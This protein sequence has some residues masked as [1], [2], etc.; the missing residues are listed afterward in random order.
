M[1]LRTFQVHYRFA[2]ADKTAPLAEW[3]ADSMDDRFGG[4]LG[5]TQTTRVSVHQTK[6]RLLAAALDAVETERGSE[7]SADEV[8]ATLVEHGLLS[9]LDRHRVVWTRLAAGPVPTFE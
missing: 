8:D 6:V 2:G 5:L 7:L 3:L 4:D 9:C 1:S